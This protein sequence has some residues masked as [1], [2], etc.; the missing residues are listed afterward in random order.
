MDAV[1]HF[2][3]GL[4][5][6]QANDYDKALVEFSRAIAAAPDYAEPYVGRGY[7]HKLNSRLAEALSDFN[8]AIRLDPHH[9]D[10]YEGR[11]SV[12]YLR[13]QFHE[14]IADYTAAIGC[15]NDRADVYHSRAMALEAI[16]EL[17]KAIEDYRSAIQ[18]N[19]HNPISQYFLANSLRL[20]GR[21]AEAIKHFRQAIALAP[22]NLDCEVYAF[23]AWVLAT[24]PHE[25]LRDGEEAVRMA[26]VA[27][28]LDDWAGEQT[29]AV[30][31][32]AH[33]ECGR[34]EDAV[35]WQEKACNLAEG[36]CRLRQ[37]E[38]LALYRRNR[39]VTGESDP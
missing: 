17:G 30:L 11:G 19:P 10:A 34:F 2:Q 22:D 25:E 35:A 33:A 32:A 36:E 8:E 38:R 3:R 37:L 4:A 5:F 23:Y 16:G 31:A 1:E 20:S 24:C 27:C 14:S 29:L 6:Y 13:C 12:Q 15:G 9:P 7:V 26:T 18:R 28:D 21:Y 39:Q